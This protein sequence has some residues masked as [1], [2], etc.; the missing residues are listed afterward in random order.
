MAI[1]NS[2]IYLKR[3]NLNYKERKYIQDIVASLEKKGVDV[4]NFIPANNFGELEKLYKE[5]AISEASFTEVPNNSNANAGGSTETKSNISESEHDDGYSA[6]IDPLNR[7]EPIVRDYVMQEESSGMRREGSVENTKTSFSEP[8]SFDESFTLPSDTQETK[9]DKKKTFSDR[10]TEDRGGGD[11]RSEIAKRESLN[12]SFDSMTAA[13]KKKKTMKLA[14]AIVRAVNKLMELGIVWYATKD[15]TDQKALEYEANDELD[16]E[17]LLTLENNQEVTVRQWF[18]IQA[19]EAKAEAKI[20]K[21]DEEDMID[22]LYEFMYEKGIAPTPTQDV[23]I[24]AGG[25]YLMKGV[26]P[27]LARTSGISA[28]LAQLKGMKIE[29]KKTNSEYRPHEDVSDHSDVNYDANP[30]TNHS[31]EHV[32]DINDNVETHENSTE[33]ATT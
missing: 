2:K 9:T 18:K 29:E 6:D 1:Q 4:T 28:V 12:P 19:K 31:D 15:I 25:I 26:V 24:T 17:I 27:A 22:S 21:E 14:T 3:G 23:L 5:Y 30:S 11:E 13:K 7:E 16:L 20:S 32:S 33:L 8:T 10:G